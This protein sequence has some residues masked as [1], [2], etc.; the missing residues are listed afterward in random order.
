MTGLPC[1]NCLNFWNKWMPRS[2]EITYTKLWKFDQLINVE[3]CRTSQLLGSANFSIS[4]SHIMIIL[5][6]NG[7]PTDTHG[8]YICTNGFSQCA[9][10]HSHWLG[11]VSKFLTCTY[12]ESWHIPTNCILE[13]QR[14]RINHSPALTGSFQAICNY[15]HL[16]LISIDIWDSFTKSSVN[17][18]CKKTSK[19]WYGSTTILTNH[20]KSASVW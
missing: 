14:Q 2:C 10:I 5:H 7:W 18:V 16:S 13:Q 11:T 8:S 6:N 9:T 17:K 20:L 4:P 3:P 15:T 12:I 1:M 19:C